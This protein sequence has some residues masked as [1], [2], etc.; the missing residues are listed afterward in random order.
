[1]GDDDENY[2]IDGKIYIT[3]IGTPYILYNGIGHVS[4]SWTSFN[5]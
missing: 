4:T 5:M 2:R 3:I 1:M